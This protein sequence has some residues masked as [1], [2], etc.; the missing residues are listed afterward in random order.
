MSNQRW[1][2]SR[3]STYQGCRQKYKLVYENELVVTGRESDLAQKGLSFHEI[4]EFMDSSKSEEDLF[5]HAKQVLE[6][7]DFDQEKYPVIKSIPRFYLWWQTYIQPKINDGWTL[8]KE[9]WENSKIDSK[10]LVGAI[11]CLLISPD[12]KSVIIIDYKTASTAKAEGYKDQLLLYAWMVAKRLKIKKY[13][14]IQC[15]VF[16]PLAGLKE[17]D[18]SNPKKTT[19]IMMQKTMKQILFTE[20]DVNEVVSKFKNII[21]ETEN[22]DWNL[23]DPEKNSS[24]N[25]TCSWCPFLGHIEY[26]PTSHNAGFHFP[27]RAKVMTKEESKKLK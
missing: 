10:D 27:R 21:D 11:D 14:N 2:A 18:N 4:A 20:D 24:M 15:Y 7:A 16:F 25:F 19:E 6:I 23:W 5:N 9:C 17:E 1:S 13:E 12:K 3:F 8:S 26:C 22:I